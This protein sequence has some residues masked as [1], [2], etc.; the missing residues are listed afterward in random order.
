MQQD[1]VNYCY[2]RTKIPKYFEEEKENV[3]PSPNAHPLPNTRPSLNASPYPSMEIKENKISSS[4]A[5]SS[6]SMEDKENE[7][8][9]PNASPSPS[10][11]SFSSSNTRHNYYIG[12]H[13]NVSAWKAPLQATSL[14]GTVETVQPVIIGTMQ[15][16]LGIELTNFAID[17][18]TALL[19]LTFV[20]LFVPS[21]ACPG[22]HLSENYYKSELWAKVLFD[23][24]TL[25]NN[26]NPIWEFHHQ[27]PGNSGRD[28][29]DP[30][31]HFEVGGVQVHKDFAVIVA[32]AAHT[33]NRILSTQF[34]NRKDLVRKW[35]LYS[36]LPI[37]PSEAEK[38]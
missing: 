10:T 28:L 34:I 12:Q 7:N 16:W 4:N 37:L 32:E 31:L 25:A 1:A 33:L 5:S 36:R 11:S 18:P 13:G 19:A 2:R 29:Y 26:F 3:S 6:S 15:R 35:K 30:T 9:S 38:S 8:P 23:S 27:I 20:L 24:F 14:E 22:G 21:P 17:I